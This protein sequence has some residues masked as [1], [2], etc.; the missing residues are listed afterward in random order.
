MAYFN[1]VEIDASRLVRFGAEFNAA[2]R[3]PGGGPQPMKDAYKQMGVIYMGYTRDRFER[4]SRGGGNWKPLSASTLKRRRKGTKTQGAKRASATAK[5]LA[6]RGVPNAGAAAILRDRGILFNSITTF[7]SQDI[8]GGIRVGSN[9]KYGEY[10]DRG[11]KN[12]RPPQRQIFV[13]PDPPTQAQMNTRL[14]VGAQRTI[15]LL[16]GGTGGTGGTGGGK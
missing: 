2:I 15:D 5:I 4:F 14:E 13:D 8:P 11:G 7:E 1:K 9:V 10:H 12:G 6:A 3:A 16:G